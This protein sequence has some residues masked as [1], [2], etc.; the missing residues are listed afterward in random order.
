MVEIAIPNA[1]SKPGFN[2]FHL[3]KKLHSTEEVKTGIAK[4]GT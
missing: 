2:H 1:I 4:L 3:K